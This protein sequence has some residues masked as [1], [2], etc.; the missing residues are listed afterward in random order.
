MQTIQISMML[1]KCN[2]N[3]NSGDF[4]LLNG[5]L[6]KGDQLCIPATSLRTALIKDLHLGGLAGHF[7]FGRDKTIHLVATRFYWPQL[8]KY[9]VIYVS[10]CFVRQTKGTKLNTGLYTPLPT[11][12]TIREDLSMDFILGLPLALI[13]S[14]LW[15]TVSARWHTF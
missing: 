6:F 11:P 2:D 7:D 8:R 1:G 9:V 13:L 5:Y 4:H 15:L 14:W 3:S 12:E 10:K